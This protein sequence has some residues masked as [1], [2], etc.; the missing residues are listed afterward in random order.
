[1]KASFTT[2]FVILG[3]LLVYGIVISGI[4]LTAHNVLHSPGCVQL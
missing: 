1:M 4:L 2:A 3:H